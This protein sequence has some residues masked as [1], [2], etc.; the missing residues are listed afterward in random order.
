MLQE[1]FEKVNIW[2]GFLAI[3]A[4]LVANC[5][6]EWM[7]LGPVSPFI[8]AIPILLVSG[9]LISFYWTENCSQDRPRIKKSCMNGLN[10]ILKDP[11]IFLTGIVQSLFES[12][13][14]IFIFIWTPVLDKAHIPLGLVF[15]CF[16]ASTMSGAGSFLMLRRWNFSVTNLL[17]SSVV[18]AAG[19][20]VVAAFAAHPE[21]PKYLLAFFSFLVIEFSVGIYFRA[22]TIVRAR[23]VPQAT[24]TAI[25]SWFRVPLNL[26][27]CLILMCLHNDVFRHGNRLIFGICALLLVIASIFVTCLVSLVRREEDFVDLVA[28]KDV[29]GGASNV[30]I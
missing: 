9:V 23:I 14:Y 2:N 11:K 17:A 7:N 30:E 4:G 29:Q 10:D 16:M 21:E 1:T 18:L 25:N 26:I 28:S 15:A 24:G 6:A 8:L 13:M 12:T 22:M 19:G 3:I 5:F 27:A 20:N